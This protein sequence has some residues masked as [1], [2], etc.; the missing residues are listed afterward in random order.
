MP[1][2]SDSD[3]PQQGC[4]VPNRVVREGILTSDPVCKMSI[5]SQLFYRCLMNKADDFGLYDARPM[6]LLGEL[7]ALQLDKW[8]L[9]DVETCLEEC[10]E[11]LLQI[12]KVDGKPYF[13]IKNWKQQTRAEK[14]KWPGPDGGM[15]KKEGKKREKHKAKE[16][17]EALKQAQVSWSASIGF[18][19]ITDKDRETWTKAYPACDLD[20]QLA[21]MHAW[22]IA[23]PAKAKKSNWR[24]FITTWL[25]KSQ[26]RGGDV[27]SNRPGIRKPEPSPSPEDTEVK[28]I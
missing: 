22:L 7:F 15:V 19:G 21:S 17:P 20:R 25:G 16:K 8:T 18:E 28:L 6:V 1:A 26:D 12:Y 10:G 23:N 4:T 14:S 2:V 3:E 13:K 27:A 11:E 9:E 24:R 5:R